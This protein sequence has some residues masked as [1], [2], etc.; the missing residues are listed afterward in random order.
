MHL[1]AP[2]A[3]GCV[4]A[5]NGSVA[6]FARGGSTRASYY[7][8]FEGLAAVTP[9]GNVALDSRGRLIAYVNRLVSCV[10]YDSAGAEVC[11]FVAGDSASGV[12]VRSQSFTGVSYTT[13]AT[14]PSSP[15]SLAE[16]LDRWL[17][18]AGADDFEVLVGGVAVSIRAALSTV[19]GLVYNVTSTVYGAIGNGTADDTAA[20]QAAI[21]ACNAAGG[22]IVWFPE[23]TYRTTS[24][25]TLSDKVSL[26][27]PGDGGAIITLDHATNHLITT[28]GSTTRHQAIVGLYLTHTQSC[29]G[30]ILN[31][32]AS[33]ELVVHGCTIG[34]ATNS[35][36]I[37]LSAS[38]ATATV[39]V[40]DSTFYWT[41]AAASTAIV[42][43]H[44]TALVRV[45][46]CRFVTP[47]APVA[48]T[49]GS[50]TGRGVVA[51]SCVFDNAAM[52]SGTWYGWVLGAN[53]INARFANCT[54][55]APAGGTCY[56]YGIGSY[57]SSAVFSEVGSSF[58]TGVTAYQYTTTAANLGAQIHL[59]TRTYRVLS[60]TNTAAT[61]TAEIKQYGYIKVVSTRA[62]NVAVD[63]D[64]FPPFGSTGVI[65]ID[66]DD[67]SNRT[68][69]P[70][71]ALFGTPGFVT[72]GAKTINASA[73]NAMTYWATEFQV[74]TNAVLS[75]VNTW[76]L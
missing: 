54:F 18:S 45:S 73:G 46:R 56:A 48:T 71:G 67:G 16:V 29:S 59:H 65:A 36:G 69:T 4:G 22:G 33:T 68:F 61:F 12:E 10:V 31:V 57:T 74:A 9:T 20:I 21:T 66:N 2:L 62:G 63:I 42:A 15:V 13:G 53:G 76:V 43:D 44:A 49:I 3:A 37:G 75:L 34:S 55:T 32:A 5:E 7:T 24:A 38:V 50:I 6:I 19:G 14:A 25:L 11:T 47:S 39:S 27:G 28:S 1:I 8:D 51:E 52:A 41:N 58:G 23:G 17:D 40:S 70:T 30:R 35:A 64:G 60:T 72:A 26:V